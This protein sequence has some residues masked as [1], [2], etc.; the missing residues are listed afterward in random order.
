[1]EISNSQ[2][3]YL[4]TIYLL[5][6][7]R[8]IRS[9]D[10]ARRLNVSKPSV[11]KMLEQ[12]RDLDLIEKEKYSEIFLT[13]KGEEIAKSFYAEYCGICDCLSSNMP[14]HNE[15]IEEGAL[16]L[17]CGYSQEHRKEFCRCIHLNEQNELEEK[18]ELINNM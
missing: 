7:N 5:K 3:K 18:Y 10:I 8:K 11:H 17:L 6:H 16:L 1:M 14:L 15:I 13:E 12:L 2:I 4:L 9:M